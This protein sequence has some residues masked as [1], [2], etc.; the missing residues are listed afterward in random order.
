M[1]EAMATYAEHYE[2]CNAAYDRGDELVKEREQ[3]TAAEIWDQ[4]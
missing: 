4:T 3:T 2:A 1:L